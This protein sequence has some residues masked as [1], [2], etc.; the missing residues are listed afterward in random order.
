MPVR[1]NIIFAVLTAL[2]LA[3]GF[4]GADIIGHFIPADTAEQTVIDRDSSNTNAVYL[5]EDIKKFDPMSL[6]SE[7]LQPQDTD[8]EKELRE[9]TAAMLTAM[10]RQNDKSYI[11]RPADTKLSDALMFDANGYIYADKWEY[12]N[13]AKETRFLDCIVWSDDLSIAYI[14][15]YG[16]DTQQLSSS[17]MNEGLDRLEQY[18]SDFYPCIADMNTS[19]FEIR[20]EMQKFNEP[21]ESEGTNFV[22]RN[23]DLICTIKICS[24]YDEADFYMHDVLVHT[25]TTDYIDSDM[26]YDIISKYR[27]Y[28]EATDELFADSDNP[29]IDF[30]LP[31]LCFRDII[32]S[33]NVCVNCGNK[34]NDIFNEQYGVWV[35]PSYSA[36]DGIIFQTI[37][38]GTHE[39]TVIYNVRDDTIEGFFFPDC[40]DIR[41]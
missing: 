7:P 35:K 38:A 6:V 9:V 27:A 2:I 1:S 19:L 39:V 14:R 37:T 33:S 29:L 23:D 4:Y 30:W 31:Q 11:F 34:V 18:S 28:R 32:T 21:S 24:S 41:L 40:S 25:V 22:H 12:I 20:D 15:F 13:S 17:E 5:N 16:D 8:S 10:A 36:K 3:L 26:L